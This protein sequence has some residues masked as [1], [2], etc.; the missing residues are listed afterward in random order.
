MPQ[1]SLEFDQLTLEKIEKVAKQDNISISAWVGNNLQKIL[2]NNYPEGFFN[3]FGAI[4]D[5]TFI[6]P[7]EINSKYDLPM[8]QI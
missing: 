7:D 4:K 1:I 6:E 8:E 3:L 2:K 5:D